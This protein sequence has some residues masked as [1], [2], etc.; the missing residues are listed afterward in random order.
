MRQVYTISLGPFLPG[1]LPSVFEGVRLN[2]LA[3]VSLQMACTSIFLP[4]PGEP[5]SSVGVPGLLTRSAP[6]GTVLSGE[7]SHTGC[8]PSGRQQ[9]S[10]TA[11]RICE[12]DGL[13]SCD[14]SSCD[15]LFIAAPRYMKEPS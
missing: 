7:W 8:E 9:N 12:S 14:G 4:V 13:G 11:L 6:L 3:P 1:N 5:V 2:R 15:S 10:V